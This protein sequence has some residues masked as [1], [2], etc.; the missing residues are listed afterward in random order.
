[1]KNVNDQFDVDGDLKDTEE[2][3]FLLVG[4]YDGKISIWEID[5]KKP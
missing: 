3:E 4:S 2:K 1:M 5:Q